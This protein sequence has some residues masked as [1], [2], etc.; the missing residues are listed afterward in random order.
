[1]ED[2]HNSALEQRP[3]IL[4]AIG[5]NVARRN[6]GFAMIDGP[7][8]ELRAI[9]PEIGFQFVR[10]DFCSDGCVLTDKILENARADILNR[11]HSEVA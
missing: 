6:V 10:V 2:S 7:M 4:D 8:C 11:L 3:D 5:V 9:Q 1:M